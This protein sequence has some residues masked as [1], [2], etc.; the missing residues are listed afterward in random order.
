NP[1]LEEKGFY[2]NVRIPQADGTALRGRIFV[3]AKNRVLYQVRYICPA[4][5]NSEYSN[6]Y[7]EVRNTIKEL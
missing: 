5:Y 6:I 2:V 1:M 4:N 3:V 7:R